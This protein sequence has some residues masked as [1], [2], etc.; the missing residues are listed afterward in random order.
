M[1]A[2]QPL[3]PKK[4][5]SE[6]CQHEGRAGQSALELSRQHLFCQPGSP[7]ASGL[8]YAACLLRHGGHEVLLVDGHLMGQSMEQLAEEVAAFSPTMTVITTAITT[9]AARTGIARALTRA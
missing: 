6:E 2:A 5:V 9:G 4:S 3:I 1:T 7:S 8:G